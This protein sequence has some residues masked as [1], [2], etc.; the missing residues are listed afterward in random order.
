MDL[1]C[2]L[3]NSNVRRRAD[4]DLSATLLGQM[5]NQIGRC[6]CL[7]R[8]WWSLDETERRDEGFFDGIHLEVVQLGQAIH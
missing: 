3:I 6:D 8:A 4:K 1:G 5:I 2:E 7:A